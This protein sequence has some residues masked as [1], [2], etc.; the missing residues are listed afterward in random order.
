[1]RIVFM[2]SA[3]LACPSLR[4]AARATACEVVAVITQPDRPRGRRLRPAPPP[5]KVAAVE[6]G[7]P[8]DQPDKIGAPAVLDRL[9]QLAPDLIVVVAY[10]QLLPKP[11]LELPPL[12][13][14]NV[15][16]S[17]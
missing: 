10:G 13:C 4:A 17:L 1:M 15:H 3:E 12:G 8:I 11:L 5:V 2:G 14:I 6:L 7:V 16:A 9:R